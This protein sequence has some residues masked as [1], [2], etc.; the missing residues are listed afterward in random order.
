MS[1]SDFYKVAQSIVNGQRVASLFMITDEDKHRVAKRSIAHA[2]AMTTLLDYEPYVDATSTIFVDRL[3][4]LFAQK[5]QVCDLGVWL[6]WYAFDVIGEMTF[7]QRLGFLEQGQDV[8]G[9]I[10]I[11]HRLGGYTALVGQMPWLDY[12]LE[13]NIVVHKLGLNRK[14]I[15]VQF[16]SGFLQRRL[17]QEKQA[18]NSTESKAQSQNV[19]CD[20]TDFLSKF[21]A[22]SKSYEG[23]IPTSQLLGWSMSNINAGSDTTAIALRAIICEYN[24]TLYADSTCS[25]DQIIF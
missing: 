21:I 10:A 23:K 24:S 13:K 4:E 7:G 22:G 17:S 3:A 8:E 5:H 9:L 18:L 12:F 19:S 6:Q 11:L 16:V 1:Q 20:R 15:I 25:F 14:R 2:Y